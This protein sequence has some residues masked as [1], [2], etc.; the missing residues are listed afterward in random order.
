MLHHPVINPHKPE[1][2]R[3]ECN[4]AAKFH[5]V[6]LN[7]KFLSWTNLLQSLIGIVFFLFREYPIALS[8]DIEAMFLQVSVPN[9]D[10]R[11]I[12]F[13]WREN[14]KQGIEVYAYT[15]HVFWAK[16]LPTCA[17]YALYQ[18]AKENLVKAVQQN[19]YM[20][21]FLKSVRTPQEEIE[22]YQKIREFPSKCGF[23]LTKWITSD[24][25]VK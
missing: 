5:G 21:D 4:A 12:Q 8:A 14:P 1:K 19:F 23:H 22:V 20:D 24:E 7:G 15:R 16:S 6:S 25:A 13:L 2:V 17:N 10:R 3:R 11:C 9:D 18:V